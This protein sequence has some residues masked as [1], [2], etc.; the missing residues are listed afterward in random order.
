M[1]TC[2]HLHACRH[3]HRHFRH[4]H[5]H[6]HACTCMQHIHTNACMHTYACMSTCTHI[7]AHAHT[8][9]EFR[10]TWNL[11]RQLWE[12]PTAW[13]QPSPTLTSYHWGTSIHTHQEQRQRTMRLRNLQTWLALFWVLSLILLIC[14]RIQSRTLPCMW[15]LCFSWLSQQDTVSYTESCWIWGW[16]GI[17]HW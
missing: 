10:R 4:A 14:S 7:H 16:R 8:F 13:Q 12:L 15:L 9:T 3:I 11:Q 17:V 6:S 1:Y 5:R 2:T